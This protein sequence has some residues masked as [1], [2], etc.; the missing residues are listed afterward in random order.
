MR[1]EIQYAPITERYWQKGDIAT[2]SHGHIR[3]GGCWF[4]FD[5]RYIV[6]EIV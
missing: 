6:K 3:L 2:I 4:S 1:V 5:D